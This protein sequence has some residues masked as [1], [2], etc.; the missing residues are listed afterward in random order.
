M[1]NRPDSSLAGPPSDKILRETVRPSPCIVPS[2][3]NRFGCSIFRSKHGGSTR[4]HRSLNQDR[5]KVNYPARSTP[6]TARARRQNGQSSQPR[7]VAVE[8]S[9][10]SVA[11]ADV[12]PAPGQ[13]PTPPAAMGPRPQSL[14]S[15]GT[16]R[17]RQF[18]AE[19]FRRAAFDSRHKGPLHA[20]E[21]APVQDR[22]NDSTRR[23]RVAEA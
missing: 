6:E 3:A 10:V 18:S 5:R 17:G 9:L 16:I 21:T 4:R 19:G 23:P 8:A 22:G 20:V 11:K 1:E 2:S 12:A 14:A 13:P 7:T 15:R